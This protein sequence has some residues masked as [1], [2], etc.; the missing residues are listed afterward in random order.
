MKAILKGVSVFFVVL[1]ALLILLSLCVRPSY[2]ALRYN[3]D[4]T[5]K[6]D[7]IDLDDL[8]KDRWT[9]V[10]QTNY[11]NGNIESE[12][13]FEKYLVNSYSISHSQFGNMSNQWILTGDTSGYNHYDY[14]EGYDPAKEKVDDEFSEFLYIRCERTLNGASDVDSVLTISGQA[15][16]A[17]NELLNFIRIQYGE[18]GKVEKQTQYLLDNTVVGYR[19]YNYDANGNLI[20]TED[21]DSNSILIGYNEYEH[22]NRV[23]INREYNIN[24][25]VAGYTETQYDLLGRISNRVAY[26]EIGEIK[27][28]ECYHYNPFEVYHSIIGYIALAIIVLLSAT[29]GVGVYDDRV[30]KRK[31]TSEQA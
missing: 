13:R 2:L 24:G 18:D 30:F 9:S 10:T 14:A 31:H 25:A 28:N 3:P 11:E 27:S 15:W 8:N 4:A 16:G 19:L 21:Y 7:Y 6:T 17:D 1:L 12:T 26:N 5:V 29:M 20:K 22:G 23:M